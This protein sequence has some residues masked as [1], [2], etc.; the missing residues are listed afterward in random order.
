MTL[1][2]ED[3]REAWEAAAAAP[4]LSQATKDRLRL[5]LWG[6]AAL[7]TGQAASASKS[8]EAA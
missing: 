4:P 5:I 7:T 2:P 3:K 6:G 8:P 1:S